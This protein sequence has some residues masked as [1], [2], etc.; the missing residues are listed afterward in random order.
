MLPDSSVPHVIGLRPTPLLFFAFGL[1]M[2]TTRL[3]AKGRLVLPVALRRA[4]AWMP[5]MRFEVVATAH[6]VL[7]KP[8]VVG[9]TSL[10]P[11]K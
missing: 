4:R 9:D 8:R 5:G 3:S 1:T 10:T 2:V 6:G 7:P 11:I